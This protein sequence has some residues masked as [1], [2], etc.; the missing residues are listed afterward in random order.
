MVSGHGVADGSGPVSVEATQE[1]L[2]VLERVRDGWER[3]DGETVLAC[4]EPS[5]GTVVIGTDAPEYWIGFDAFAEPFRQM[6]N[7]F[8]NAAYRWADGPSV[9]VQ[10]G[11]AW[12]TGRLIGLFESEGE[13]VELDMRTTHV[14]RR[15]PDGWR[16]VQGHYSVAAAEPVGY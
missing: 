4:F 6:A 1:V 8:S 14:L 9:E 16:I 3:M 15:G 10:D 5:A 2:E 7:T 12:S 11:V 13:R